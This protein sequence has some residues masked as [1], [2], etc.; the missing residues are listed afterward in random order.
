M[1]LLE[2]KHDKFNVIYNINNIFGVDMN[3][4][5]RLC[6]MQNGDIHI[7]YNGF[8][9][10]DDSLLVKM[11][12]RRV[13]FNDTSNTIYMLPEEDLL[14]ADCKSVEK[15]CVSFTHDIVLYHIQNGLSVYQKGNL[16]HHESK[17]MHDLCADPNVEWSLSTPAVSYGAECISI[18][19]IKIK[20]ID[21]L[22]HLF[23]GSHLPQIDWSKIKR[24]GKYL[25]L[26]FIF[27]FNAHFQ[28]TKISP[29]FIP[30]DEHHSHLPYLLAFP[31][32]L[33][34]NPQ[35]DGIFIT[36][37][38][39]DERCKILQL[40]LNETRKLLD[41][42]F[43][44]MM[45]T[46]DIFKPMITH[47][48]Y[49]NEWNAGDDA[50]MMIFKYINQQH[51]FYH[52][53]FA[54]KITDA[55]N[56]INTTNTTNTTIT[57]YGGGDIINPYFVTGNQSAHKIAF[58]VGI[59]YLDQ[60]HL[61]NQFDEI[62]LRNSRDVSRVHTILGP[63]KHVVA[64]PD[65]AWVLP[66][67]HSP[68]K[69]NIQTTR[70]LLGVSLP[71]T[72]Y[73]AHYPDEYCR[74]VTAFTQVIKRLICTYD[75][76]LIPFCINPNNCKENDMIMCDQLIELVNDS[77][78]L[79]ICQIP[80][81]DAYVTAILDYVNS[82]D[83]MI[84]GRFHAHIFAAICNVPFVS[85]SCSRKCSELMHEWNMSNYLYQFK[86]NNIDIPIGFDADTFCEWMLNKV[87]DPILSKQVDLVSATNNAQVDCIISMFVCSL[88]RAISLTC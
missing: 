3:Q 11:M 12:K 80:L 84:C 8:F 64:I 30:T 54:K 86:T 15:N 34:Y 35:H 9:I 10:A 67:V 33:A 55:A 21:K 77:E 75:V 17:L 46:S 28:I 32:G 7:T 73:N 57:V 42:P 38:E 24:H 31:T 82:M 65:V 27:T 87:N 56:T 69:I 5:A 61:L 41:M 72:Y 13:I 60:L 37:G 50:F 79:H 59:P 47:I 51:P 22:D 2:Y 29:P 53:K 19:H 74:L 39:G 49:F 18:G 44:I 45:L 83:F 43:E 48:G 88:K 40:T 66:R 26:M 1:C 16:V 62:F 4:D 63:N 68:Q 58:G 52:C 78:H 71:R 81:T 36:Y 6:K 20:Y 76:Y 23:C 85:L 25:Y 70:K 14:P